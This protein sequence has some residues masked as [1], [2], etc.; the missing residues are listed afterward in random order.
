[1]NVGIGTGL[2]AAEAVKIIGAARLLDLT[3]RLAC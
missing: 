2:V 3:L 1:L